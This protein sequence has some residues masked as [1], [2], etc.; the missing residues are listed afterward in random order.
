MTDQNKELLENGGIGA[1]SS[2]NKALARRLVFFNDNTNKTS[3]YVICGKAYP[4]A[5]LLDCDDLLT[6]IYPLW[7]NNTD[8]NIVIQDLRELSTKPVK[9]SNLFKGYPDLTSANSGSIIYNNNT[10]DTFETMTIGQ[11]GIFNFSCGILLPSAT[12]RQNI[13][14]FKSKNEY[15]MIDEG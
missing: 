14:F 12:D 6:S 3:S 15:T 10:L 2:S 8:N 7:S 9:Y 1:L 4:N 11:S 13:G 5:D